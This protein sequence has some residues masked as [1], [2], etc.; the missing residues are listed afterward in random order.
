MKKVLSKVLAIALAAICVAGFA[1]CG[2]FYNPDYSQRKPDAQPTD[3]RRTLYWNP[4][5]K[6][7]EKGQATVKFYNNARTTQISVDV[8]GQSQDGTL[9]W[10]DTTEQ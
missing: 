9:L 1:A 10:N 2:E 5:V 3:Y 8:A 4:N 6:L 7:D